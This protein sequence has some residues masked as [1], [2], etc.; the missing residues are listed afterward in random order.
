M[1][2]LVEP[3]ALR[4]AA[5]GL[6]SDAKPGADANDN[7]WEN[8]ITFTP[9]GCGVV[10]GHIWG[11]P[12]EDKSDFQG[13][14][15][16]AD[17]SPILLETGLEWSTLDMKADPKRLVTETL[18]LGTSSALERILAMGLT[19]DAGPIVKTALSQ[20]ISVADIS[21]K[22]IATGVNHPNFKALVATPNAKTASDAKNFALL[23]AK[24]LD[25]SDHTG[26]AGTIFMSPTDAY[27]VHDLFVEVDGRLYSKLTGSQ[28]IIGNFL[29]GTAYGVMGDVELYLSDVDVY[30]TVDR[31]TNSWYGRAERKAI[32]KFNTCAVFGQGMSGLTP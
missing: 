16:A 1:R 4:Q 24:L 10:F 17:F 21:G 12:A 22:I 30:T 19:D 13:C 2:E 8:G 7:R 31:K 14:A 15:P 3:S 28:I 6:V 9:Q 25:A 27:M 11:C 26:S 23:E 18:E 20:S 29:P 5:H 32:V